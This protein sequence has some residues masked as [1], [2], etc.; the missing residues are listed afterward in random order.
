MATGNTGMLLRSQGRLQE[1]IAHFQETL[2]LSNDL[3]DKS[4]AA[5][6]FQATGE[7]MIEKGDLAGAHEMYQQALAI[8]KEI[9]EKS[10]YASTLVDE[11]TVLKEEA[12][13]DKARSTYQEAL[14]IQQQMGAKSVAAETQLA[15]AG[16][17][18]D[19]GRASDAEQIAKIALREF[20][21]QKE[22]EQEI[23]AEITLS[24]SL[25]QQGKIRDANDC[26][27]KALILSKKSPDIFSRLTLTLNRATILAATKDMLGAE[28][29]ARQVLSQTERLGLLRLHLEASLA[30][31]EVQMQSKN[32]EV[33]RKRLK[34]TETTAR[35]KGFNLVAQRA[36]AT[37][38]TPSVR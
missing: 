23:Y 31:G 30:L 3:G 14:S 36:S 15:L 16:L 6:A 19:S 13:L 26:I 29:A 37:L 18:L 20:E 5:L 24:R 22:P 11:G 28:N 21:K 17:D 34:E 1:A 33:G 8:Q 7:V 25:L 2:R 38:Q 10:Y 32:P 27:V 35:S 12:D 4:S 9:S